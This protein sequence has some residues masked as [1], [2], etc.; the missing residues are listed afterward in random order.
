MTNIE[1]LEKFKSKRNNVYKVRFN[2]TALNEIT[3]TKIIDDSS[4]DI[5]DNNCLINMKNGIYIMKKYSIHNISNPEREYRNI[6]MLQD[7]GVLVPK[8]IYKENDSLFFE[9]IPGELIGDLVESQSIGSWIDEFALWMVNLHKI[10]GS[11]GN[12]LK[13]DVNLRNFI[14]AKGKIYGLD[15]EDLSYGDIRTDLADIC[16]FILTDTPSFT[17]EKHTIMRRFLHS[18]EQH[19][20][21]KLKEVGRY[22]LKSRE[23]A[24]IR[25]NQNA[26]PLY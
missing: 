22:L 21:I 11:S 25:R 3:V 10:S 4:K 6:K 17:I 16:F 19:S 15:F 14:Y 18:Y 5:F 2:N 8:V 7:S 23:K 9:Y 24:R 12:L 1:I 26:I 20:G 13:G